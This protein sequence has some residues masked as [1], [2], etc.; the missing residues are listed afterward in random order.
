M[1]LAWSEKTK[2]NKQT[3]KQN[4]YKE[5][6]VRFFKDILSFNWKWWYEFEIKELDLCEDTSENHQKYMRKILRA[7]NLFL[8]K[9]SQENKLE[10]EHPQP[11]VFATV[12]LMSLGK[13]LVCGPR[14]G[15]ILMAQ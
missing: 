7:K 6:M 10:F 9:W 14:N 1:D 2:N 13:V 8:V 11:L 3:N 15:L 4:Q 12:K 5:K